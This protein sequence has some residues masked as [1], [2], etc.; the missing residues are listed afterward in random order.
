[1][2]FFNT[3]GPVNPHDHYYLDSESRFNEQEIFDL[4]EQKKYFV[5]HAPRQ[6]GKTSTI[7]NFVQQLNRDGQYTAL[8]VNIEAAQALRSNVEQGMAVIL[9]EF[10]D[11][12]KR[13]LPGEQEVITYLTQ[14]IK[15]KDF[16][17]ASLVS[18]LR[19][20]ATVSKKAL[21]L[22]IDEIDSVVGDTLISVLRQLRTGYADRPHA[23]PQSVCLTGVRDVRDYRVWSEQDQQMVLGGSA[24]N[25]KSKS[26]RLKD[27]SEED[28]QS[29]Y[30]QHTQATGQVFTQDA[31]EYAFYLTQGQPWLVN[32][33][34]YEACFEMVK[35]RDKP[36]TKEI[37]ERAKEIIIKR[38]DTHLDVLVDFLQEP[39]V[40]EIIDAIIT[41]IDTSINFP[42]DN[43]Q[44]VID[45]GLVTRKDNTLAIAN[46]IYQEV[47]PR[48]LTYSTQL[49]MPIQQ[50]WY[51]RPD[52]SLDME[53]MLSSFT[54][55]YRENSAI[56]LEKFAYK[57]S[58]PHLFTMAFL[59][60]IVNGGGKIHREYALGTDRVDLLIMW[61][62]QRFVIEMK[63][64]RSEKKT[65]RAGLEQTAR[66][67][68]TAGA[69]EGHLIIFDKSDKS[70][71]EKI[72]KR[73]EFFA[74]HQITVWGM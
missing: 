24:F 49:T 38:R 71:N 52:G 20:W 10:L 25:I 40:R 3:S 67:M 34:A 19:Y 1:M 63:V 35:E 70:W 4:I 2:K 65:L 46:P 6:T 16:S 44:Y 5:L 9:R 30:Q 42:I 47:L 74:G 17:G 18:M 69:T 39:R 31:I 57:E 15:N 45:L 14:E 66:Y 8:Y 21:V 23:F 29:L 33:L 73:Q 72:Y 37:I 61:K 27:F 55:F 7:M 32:A 13:Q 11:Q 56:W 64:W 50:L 58:G 54:E 26:L 68:D 41:G 60:R 28:V 48:E 12:I 36:I 22:F 53:K 51:V 43:I 59:Q 62:S